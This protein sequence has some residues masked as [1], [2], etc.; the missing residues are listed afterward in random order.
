MK[1]FTY[2]LAGCFAVLII[3]FGFAACEQKKNG[4]GDIGGG[5]TT[6]GGTTGGGTTGGSTTT[7]PDANTLVGTW[8]YTG[9]DGY[10]GSITVTLVVN[11]DHTGSQT[12]TEAGYRPTTMPFSWNYNV[13]TEVITIILQDPEYGGTYPAKYKIGWFGLDRFYV[14]P[15][16]DGTYYDDELMGPFVRQSGGGTATTPSAEESQLLGTWKY[17]GTDGY[18]GSITV[19]L[20]VKADHTGSQTVTE[21]GYGSTTMP[22]SWNYNASTEVITIILQDPYYGGAYPVKYKIEWFGKD[23]FFV[24]PMSDGY[25]YDD[26]LMGPF[27][28]Q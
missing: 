23:R 13:S 20:V 10:N 6:G 12:V 26:E 25:Y 19:T 21:A 4:G 27:V 2:L 1:K 14:Y 24:Y 11:A 17:S 9:T 3:A 16:S 18:N 7:T 28:R 8:K 22:F 15:M 5:T